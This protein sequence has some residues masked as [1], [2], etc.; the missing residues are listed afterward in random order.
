MAQQHTMI[1]LLGLLGPG[2]NSQE[3]ANIQQHL[4]S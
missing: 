4:A 3:P 1:T 2:K